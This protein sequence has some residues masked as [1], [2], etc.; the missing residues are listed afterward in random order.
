MEEWVRNRKLYH[1]FDKVNPGGLRLCSGRI[2]LPGPGSEG[3]EEK[4]DS[5]F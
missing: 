3:C 1:R 5:R 4:S 2:Q